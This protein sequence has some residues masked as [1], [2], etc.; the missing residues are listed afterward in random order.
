MMSSEF[1]NHSSFVLGVYRRIFGEKVIL[2]G[3]HFPGCFYN[4]FVFNFSRAKVPQ[5]LVQRV[6]VYGFLSEIK[7]QSCENYRLHVYRL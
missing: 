6:Y 2:E 4:V 7:Q 5:T 3:R 1:I